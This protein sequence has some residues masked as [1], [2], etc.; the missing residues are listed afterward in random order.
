M[1]AT[2]ANAIAENFM[3]DMSISILQRTS[4]GC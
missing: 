1:E 2:R 4:V 3:N